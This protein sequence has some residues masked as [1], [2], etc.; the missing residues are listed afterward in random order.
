VIRLLINALHDTHAPT[1]MHG[2]IAR[3]RDVPFLR[4]LLRSIGPEPSTS[5]KTNLKRLAFI[6]WLRDD[7]GLL[8]A[9]NEEEQRTAIQVALASGMKRL[10]VFEV[11]KYL[12]QHGE[13]GVQREA[14]RALIHFKGAD[15]NEL[16]LKALN[17]DDPEL[18]AVAVGQLR[19]RGIPNAMATLIELIDSPHEIVRLAATESLSEFRFERYLEKFDFLD[20]E[21][22]EDNGRLVKRV[23]PKAVARLTEELKASSRARRLRGVALTIAMDAVADVEESL[24]E[25]L[26]DEDQFVRIEALHALTD[27]DSPQLRT[28]VRRLRDDPSAVVREA[29][30]SIL[31][32]WGE[33]VPLSAGEA[34]DL[35]GEPDFSPREE[36]NQ[37]L[38]VES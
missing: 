11:V 28:T 7:L 23:D 4:G 20:E 25:L 13:R 21:Q 17:S 35:F 37:A 32:G 16:L 12:L 24:I 31:R 18:Q 30:E 10:E 33:P 14:A 3:R 6:S 38:E 15:A 19:D 2:V 5:L 27:C 22:R 29:A 9:L 8:S 1:A 34:T 26:A 36:N